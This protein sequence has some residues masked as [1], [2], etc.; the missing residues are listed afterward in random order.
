M[1]LVTIAD[2]EE[3]LG[4]E[5]SSE[6][7]NPTQFLLDKISAYIETYTGI[8]FSLVEE[9]E[10]KLTSDYYGI[11]DLPGP[12]IEVLGVKNWRDDSDVF[13]WDFNGDS[14]LSG[15]Y[16][17]Q[18]VV[19]TLSYGYETVPSDIKLVALDMAVSATAAPRISEVT[20][21]TVGDVSEKFAAYSSLA[22]FM[23]EFS[24]SV[25][26]SY[27]VSEWSQR[28]GD[29]SSWSSAATNLPTM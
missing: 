3:A 20:M 27:R 11:I 16:P 12:V 13:Y 9:A 21:K 29:H 15:F 10:V 28:L 26:D 1:S 2:L 17:D 18:T 8:T 4:I 19:V 24:K 6:D 22:N 14:E 5:I 7:I 25:L 23:D